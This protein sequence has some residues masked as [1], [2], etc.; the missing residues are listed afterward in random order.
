VAVEREAAS[1][2][3]RTGLRV[4]MLR[5]APTLGDHRSLLARV[6]ATPV[7]PAV[8]GTDPLLQV[9]DVDDLVEATRAVAQARWD[10][11]LNVAAPGVLPLSTVIKL[12]GRLRAPTL[13]TVLRVALQACWV[14]GA[15]LVPPAHAAYLRETFVADT[16][17]AERTLG[18]RAR[19]AIGD[20]LARHWARRHAPLRF[21]A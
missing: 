6:L 3:E 11:P 2:R 5:C 21:A 18:W 15:G 13:D 19:Y 4:A 12:S 7:V 8:L 16:A 17:R 1:L 9:L 10:G 20:V 14:V